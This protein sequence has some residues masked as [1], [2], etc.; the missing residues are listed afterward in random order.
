MMELDLAQEGHTGKSSGCSQVNVCWFGV[1]GS[2]M[3]LLLSADVWHHILA[4][5]LPF[6]GWIVEC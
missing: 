2:M 1:K 3:G 6:E 5:A 4:A